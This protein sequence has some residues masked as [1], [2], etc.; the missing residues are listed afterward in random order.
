M[1]VKTVGVEVGL[2]DEDVVRPVQQGKLPGDESVEAADSTDDI[3]RV[4]TVDV[5]VGLDDEDEVRPVQQGKLSGD[6]PIEPDEVR[7]G[8]VILFL[9]V[10]AGDAFLTGEAVLIFWRRCSLCNLWTTSA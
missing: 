3:V 7:A 1:R 10:L 9:C 4:K 5:E 6:E 8:R 2:D